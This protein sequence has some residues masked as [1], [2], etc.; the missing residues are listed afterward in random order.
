[1]VKT[2]KNPTWMAGWWRESIQGFGT[3]WSWGFIEPR[4][5]CGYL[6]WN[7]ASGPSPQDLL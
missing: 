2:T 1:M 3:V 5:T 7:K 6:T 4:S